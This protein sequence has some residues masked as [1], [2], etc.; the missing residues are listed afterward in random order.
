MAQGAT[1]DGDRNLG[2]SPIHLRKHQKNLKKKPLT[3][4]PLFIVIPHL[5]DFRRL[6]LMFLKLYPQLF[7]IFIHYLQRI[8]SERNLD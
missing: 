4:K 3:A 6:L 7:I 1:A 2:L 8:Y 5:Y